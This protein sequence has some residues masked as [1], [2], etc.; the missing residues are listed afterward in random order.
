MYKRSPRFILDI[1]EKL[2]QLLKYM[3]LV[4]LLIVAP[5]YAQAAYKV[6]NGTIYHNNQPIPL[7][8]VN[9][10]GFETTDHVVHGLWDRGYKSMISQMKNMGFQAVR[11]PF[12]PE[13]LQ[14]VDVKTWLDP[15]KNPDLVGLKSLEILDKII[16]ELNVQQM[17]ILL[18]HHRPDCLTISELW[19]TDNYTEEQWI[20]DLVLVAE[21]YKGVN[22]FMGIDLKNEPHGQATWGTGNINTDWN[23]A[24]ERAYQA[25]LAVNSDILIFVEGIQENPSCSFYPPH[26]WGE[27]LAP[28]QCVPINI[29]SEKLVF[30]PHVYGPDVANPAYFNEP[31]FPDNMPTIWNAHFGYLV[32]VAIG[33]FGG[34]YGHSCSVDPQADPRGVLWENAIIDYFINKSICNFF[35]WSWNANSRDTCGILQDDWTSIW[36][37]KY[38]NLQRL[39]MS[40]RSHFSF[41]NDVIIDFGPSYG[42]YVRLNN[43]SW[44]SLHSLSAKRMVTGDLDGNVQDEVIIDFGDTYGLWVRMNN[45][46]WVQLHRLSAKSMVTGDLDNSGQD[47]V[48][49]DFG[50]T[51]GLWIRMNNSSWTQLHSLSADS[52][53]TGDLDGN[54]EDEVIIDFG[55]TYGLW[56]RM[57]NSSWTQLHSL[58]AKIMVTGDLDNSGQDEVII[59]FGDS[60]GL[61]I[62]M[63]NSSWTQLHNLSA[64]SMVTADLDGNRE[65]EVIIDFGDTYGLWIRMN[66]SSWTQLHSLSAKSM[67]TGDLDNSGQDEVII[68][69]GD[70]YGLW[71]RMNNSSWSKLHSLSAK[72]MVTT[73]I[74]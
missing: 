22:Y 37:D 47:E 60:Y 15:S 46:S 7:F 16:A 34:Q 9:W 14:N 20:N 27:N 70:S 73:Q 5:M 28:Q 32:G 33:E 21:R 35:Y 63:N 39:M 38:D 18:D 44:V 11:I 23:L 67:V 55:E 3:T 68:D 50:D 42:I 1:K 74:E 2:M 54:G 8:G 58:S 30:S 40:C 41:D 12:C 36:Q 17:Y 13:T 62:R 6:V 4:T 66:N 56:I 25:I 53:V 10:F 52:M 19:Y 51:Y 29:P 48:I 45:S 64:N 49:I 59:D 69:F 72:S 71:I 61:W 31:E 24:A 65:D 57:N 43:N 26:F